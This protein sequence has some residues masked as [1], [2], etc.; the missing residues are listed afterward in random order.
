MFCTLSINM[1]N[2]AQPVVLEGHSAFVPEEA[3]SCIDP[4]D[5]EAAAE[6]GAGP[7]QRPSRPSNKTVTSVESQRVFH[8]TMNQHR[9]ANLASAGHTGR[10]VV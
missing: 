6:S 9:R 8:Y 5:K 2:V 3:V 10:G 7:C 4:S 1:I